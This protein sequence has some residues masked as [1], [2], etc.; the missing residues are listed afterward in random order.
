M[1]ALHAVTLDFAT[2]MASRNESD[3][4]IHH[5]IIYTVW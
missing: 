3:K 4:S 1:Q 5:N 2:I